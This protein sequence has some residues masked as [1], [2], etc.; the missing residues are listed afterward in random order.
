[1]EKNHRPIA[2]APDA[3]SLTWD[4]PGN[5]EIELTELKQQIAEML[6]REAIRQLPISYARFARTKDVDALVGLYAK[7]ATLDVAENMSMQAGPCSGLEAIRKTLRADL[8]RMDS[9]PFIHSHHF[10][11]L[12]NGSAQG[13]V[14]IELQICVE[15]LGVSYIGCYQDQYVKEDGVWKFRS[16]KLCAIPLPAPAA[17]HD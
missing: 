5:G 6:D 14:Y 8:P 15:G 1:M 3:L 4:E 16:R 9:Y 10:E 2:A 12:G 17:G 7:D 11:M 13:F